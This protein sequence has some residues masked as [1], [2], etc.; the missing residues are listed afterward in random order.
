VIAADR[1]PKPIWA[2]LT[3]EAGGYDK[4]I[5]A[6]KTIEREAKRPKKAGAF[7]A[8][9]DP[10]ATLLSEFDRTVLVNEQSK[11]K[12]FGQPF[13]KAYRE[14]ILRHAY[15]LYLSSLVGGDR[16]GCAGESALPR[17]DVPVGRVLSGHSD[18]I[19]LSV[20]TDK[21]DYVN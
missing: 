3:R 11:Q 19:R 6:R 2:A 17:E 10:L 15:R 18:L 8:A 9:A 21:I 13:P 7:A 20:T 5:K 4:A 12:A 16:P 14:S 1:V